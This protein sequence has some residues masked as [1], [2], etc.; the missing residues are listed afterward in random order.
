M[1]INTIE[2][3][4][5]LELHMKYG[6]KT[7][8]E[9]YDEKKIFILVGPPSVG[10]S[11]WIKKYFG[12]DKPYVISRDDIVEDVAEKMGFTYDDLFEKPNIDAHIG[13]MHDKYGKVIESPP[14][15]SFTKLSYQKIADA[16]KSV[17]DL[18]DERVKNASGQ[19]NIVVDMTNIGTISRK[20]ILN[21]LSPISDGYKKIAV[22]F[23]FKGGEDIIKKMAQKRSEEYKSMGKSKTLPPEVIDKM[24]SNYQEIQN[25]EG[26]DEIIH[27]DNIPSMKV[28]IK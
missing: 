1:K 4:Q 21:K 26:F 6:Y 9:N 23:N 13:D 24:F 18:F 11:T 2:K 15:M 8:M 27:V 14:W 10:K 22:V 20:N 3:K 19:K 28:S 12:A 17:I 5:I 16:N 7:I 25:D